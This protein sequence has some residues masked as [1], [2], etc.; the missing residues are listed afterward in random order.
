MAADVRLLRA[1]RIS[2]NAARRSVNLRHAEESA[3]RAVA[4]NPQN[5]EG[6]QWLTIAE[7]D[8]RS[9]TGT[10]CPRCITVKAGE[11]PL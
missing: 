10:V 1:G 3:R 7:Y 6:S 2:E 11:T 9:S 8:Q 5:N 4:A